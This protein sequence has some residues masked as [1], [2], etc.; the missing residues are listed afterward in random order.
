MARVKAVNEMPINKAAA[1]F[2]DD[3]TP[4]VTEPAVLSLIRWGLDNG[5]VPVPVAP[6]YPDPDRMNAQVDAMTR[7]EPGRAV[8]FLTNPESPEDTVLTAE[9]LEAQETSE[10]AAE[11]L[12]ENLYYAMVANAR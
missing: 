1:Q 9:D 12:I 11:L 7:W 4:L 6:G 2:L 8:K 10:D 3:K 5:I